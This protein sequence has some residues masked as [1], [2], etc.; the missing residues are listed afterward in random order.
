[1]GSTPPSGFLFL[2][3]EPLQ[4]AL[5]HKHASS[6]ED[7]A[8]VQHRPSSVSKV[9]FGDLLLAGVLPAIPCP[10]A[11]SRHGL[12]P[13]Y[14]SVVSRPTLRLSIPDRSKKPD[15][16]EVKIVQAVRRKFAFHESGHGISQGSSILI[17]RMKRHCRQLIVLAECFLRC[18]RHFCAIWSGLFCESNYKPP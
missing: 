11:C 14:P 13:E 2:F 12:S 4:Q 1:M 9:R 15:Q 7:Q 17:K 6:H 8:R 5:F 16:S 18:N 3:R 10:Q